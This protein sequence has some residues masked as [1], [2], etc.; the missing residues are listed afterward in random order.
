MPADPNQVI[1]V[2]T[3]FKEQNQ[4]STAGTNAS[5]LLPSTFQGQ[6]N[7][8]SKADTVNTIVVNNSNPSQISVSTVT[9]ANIITSTET[10]KVLYAS[11]LG[12]SQTGPQ[13]SQGPVGSTGATGATGATGGRGATGV[14]G[15]VGESAYELAIALG[16]DGNEQD[17][18]NSLVGSTGATGGRGA[19]GATGATGSQGLRGTT[20]SSIVNVTVNQGYELEVEV[21]DYQAQNT[22]VYGPWNVRGSTGSTG[23]TGATGS[24]PSTYVISIN[25]Q[26]GEVN[27]FA[28]LNIE[29]TFSSFQKFSSGISASYAIIDGMPFNNSASNDYSSLFIGQGGASQE[30]GTKVNLGIGYNSLLRNTTGAENLAIGFESLKNNID[31]NNNI[32]L[33]YGSLLSNISGYRNVAIGLG[34]ISSATGSS[35]FS[36]DTENE[37]NNYCYGLIAIGY[38]S[39]SLNSGKESIG[40]GTRACHSGSSVTTGNIAIGKSSLYKNET[41]SDN[42]AIGYHSQIGPRFDADP[43]SGEGN[44]SLGKMSLQN[45]STGADN[46]AIGVRSMGFDG[47]EL[48]NPPLN[49][50][51]TTGNAN[52]A[53]G[54]ESATLLTSG[55][56]NVGIGY[57]S[58]LTNTIGSYNTAIGTNSMGNNQYLI[59][60]QAIQITGEYNVAN[61]ASSLQR[62][63]SGSYNSA[64]GSRSLSGI[65]SSY[66]NTAVGYDAGRF[67]GGSALLT[68]ATA[69]IYIGY[70][71]RASQNNQINEIV[72]G[73]QSVG[74]GSNTAVIGATTQSSAF[75][76]GVVNAMSGISAPGATFTG[77]ISAPNIVNSINGIT[78][79]MYLFGGSGITLSVGSSG[80]TFSIISTISPKGT[81]GDIQLRNADGSDLERVTGFKFDTG[82]SILSIPGGISLIDQNSFITFQDGTTQGTAASRFT[83]TEGITSPSSPFPGDKWFKTDDGIIFIRSSTGIWITN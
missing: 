24:L 66:Y 64:F 58:L 49:Q 80:I 16:F 4:V 21:Y 70:L 59:I 44:I 1:L 68:S 22:L 39:M 55:S 13:G 52:V 6:T 73:S 12:P 10:T 54:F 15:S 62:I 37:P 79:S 17:W 65:T 56:N 40:I 60:P 32:A 53:I 41:G 63:I 43:Y 57:Q 42:I 61:G 2:V 34:T 26:T 74:M 11:S 36:I 35:I 30:A 50:P 33:G 51:E 23:A 81:E 9:T 27:N 7:L 31:G 8:T 18:I 19:T 83:Y 72:I 47:A 77:N 46:V 45:I 28:K 67:I 75:I 82:T 20:G 48:Q 38:E 69:G 14:A 25:G 71:S 76:Y 5:S 78:G 3:T 29:Q